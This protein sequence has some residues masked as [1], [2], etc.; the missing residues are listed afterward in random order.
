M[1]GNTSF[2]QEAVLK[3]SARS[4]H[5]IIQPAGQFPVRLSLLLVL[6][7][8]PLLVAGSAAAGT[9]GG[10]DTFLRAEYLVLGA[11]ASGQA[12][13]VLV[14]ADEKPKVRGDEFG[15]DLQ[16]EA[17][18]EKGTRNLGRKVKASLLS[19]VLPGAG[20][21]YVGDRPRA[22]LM[23]GIEAG[24]WGA[25]LV[26]DHNGDSWRDSAVD[27]A[28][29][30]AGTS[31]S[32]NEAYWIN[33]GSYM[34]SDAYYDALAREARALEEPSPAPISAADSWQWVNNERRQDFW[35]LWGDA[36]DSYD[37]RDYMIAFAI[38]NRVVS[39]VDAVLGV[40]RM[41][42]S[43]ESRIMGLDLELAVVPELPNPGARWTVSRRF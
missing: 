29:V 28:M 43:L 22:C 32:H 39:M 2:F 3:E 5:L 27:Y 38:V 13:A 37:R 41:D 15:W 35:R 16:D 14:A 11:G 31:G 9:V 17:Q 36:H 26:F 6:L 1:Q 20:Q 7:S 4:R 25:Y 21:W 23:G 33:V 12:T 30:Y 40:D 42:G 34:D 24:I 10:S 8:V 18:A 19:A